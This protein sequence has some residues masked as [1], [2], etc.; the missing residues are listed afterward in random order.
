MSP[1]EERPEEMRGNVIGKI[2]SYYIARRQILRVDDM[3]MKIQ[4]LGTNSIIVMMGNGHIVLL[5]SR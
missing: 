2:Y 3:C 1:L 4:P 5:L